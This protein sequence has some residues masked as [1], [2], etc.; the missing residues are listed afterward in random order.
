[1]PAPKD[2]LGLAAVDNLISKVLLPDLVGR[3]NV[4]KSELDLLHF[5]ARLGC[6]GLPCLSAM[7][8]FEL[9]ELQTM[10]NIQVEE[11]CQQ[12][13]SHAIPKL[14]VVHKEAVEMRNLWKS[15]HRKLKQAA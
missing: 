8:P 13:T 11:I 15:K 3:G 6:I 10:T 12:N 2:T 1:M 7:A 14:K 5:P 4:P 9:S